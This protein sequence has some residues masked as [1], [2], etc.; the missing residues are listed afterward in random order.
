MRGLVDQLT[1]EREAGPRPELLPGM[2][3][4]IVIGS[5]TVAQARSNHG[6]SATPLSA[7]QLRVIGGG[8]PL[9]PGLRRVMEAFFQTDF[10][11]VRVHEGPA[12]RSMG[13]LAFTLGEDLHFAPGLYDPSSRAGVELLGHELTHVVQQR[14][15]RVINPFGTGAAI[16][17]DPALEMEADTMGRQV[18]EH[19]WR[20]LTALRLQAP[21]LGRGHISSREARRIAPRPGSRESSLLMLHRLTAV[22]TRHHPSLSPRALQ[23]MQAHRDTIKEE[24]VDMDAEILVANFKA[25]GARKCADGT[26]YACFLNEDL[27][28]SNIARQVVAQSDRY[29]TAGDS[30]D[31][32]SYTR[33]GGH[34]ERLAIKKWA[35]EQGLAYSQIASTL[36]ERCKHSL[37]GQKI[38]MFTERAPCESC[39]SWLEAF[40]SA[41]EVPK[42]TVYYVA[43]LQPNTRESDE[44]M[45]L[46]FKEIGVTKK[47]GP[48]LVFE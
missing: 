25:V 28:N 38:Y 1:S 16:V 42:I 8:R 19:A 22:N 35:K 41:A 14:A 30:V 15:G 20:D 5:R 40:A 36:G 12:A 33:T 18:V 11:G 26:N 34:A 32:D 23:P 13:A 46:Y 17:Q 39:K 29:Y 27:E 6:V 3:P 43:G 48:H 2:G 7:G 37:R 45:K 10:S 44:Q 4:A 24:E 31:A 21:H 9:E 47:S